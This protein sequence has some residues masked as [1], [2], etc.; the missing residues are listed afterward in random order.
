[1]RLYLLESALSRGFD[2]FRAHHYFKQL[3]DLAI[4]CDPLARNGQPYHSPVSLSHFVR[5]HVAVDVHGGADVCVAHQF[6][7]DR[8]RSSH[9]IFSG[10]SLDSTAG[11]AAVTTINGRVLSLSGSITMVNTV[12][13]VPAP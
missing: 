13:N 12:I 8:Y 5:H 10:G 7:L 2:S 6:L 11:V 1:V 3:A 4:R 9:R